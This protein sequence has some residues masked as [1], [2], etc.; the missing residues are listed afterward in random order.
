[1]PRDL[2]NGI[3]FCIIF[4]T[5]FARMWHS[6]CDQFSFFQTEMNIHSMHVS[7]IWRMWQYELNKCRSRGSVGHGSILHFLYWHLELY[8]SKWMSKS[9]PSLLWTEWNSKTPRNPKTTLFQIVDWIGRIF[10]FFFNVNE[11]ASIR[12]FFIEKCSTIN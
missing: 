1:M 9:G 10:K 2:S 11:L 8:A 5:H 3:F 7:H 4:T 12:V 6:L